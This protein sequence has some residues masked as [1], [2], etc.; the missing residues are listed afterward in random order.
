[1][2]WLLGIFVAVLVVWSVLEARSVD[3][4]LTDMDSRVRHAR[5]SIEEHAEYADER[6]D[7]MIELIA[8][9]AETKVEVKGAPKQKRKKA[10]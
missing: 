5:R 1:M 9:I 10:P 7:L 2:I 8:Q 4:R 6:H 3:R